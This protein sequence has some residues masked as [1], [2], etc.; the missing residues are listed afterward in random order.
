MWWIL[1]WLRAEEFGSPNVGLQ[2]AGGRWQA[3]RVQWV[4]NREPVAEWRVARSGEWEDTNTSRA[5]IGRTQG[6]IWPKASIDDGRPCKHTSGTDRTSF[7]LEQIIPLPLNV[8]CLVLRVQ[9]LC[10]VRSPCRTWTPDLQ[11]A[12]TCVGAQCLTS[13]C[14]GPYSWG[15]HTGHCWLRSMFHRLALYSGEIPSLFCIKRETLMCYVYI[16]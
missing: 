14:P 15:I 11:P 5:A 9:T 12:V 10:Y 6:R 4:C 16:I 3:G 7:K 13:V 8:L 1:G 2:R